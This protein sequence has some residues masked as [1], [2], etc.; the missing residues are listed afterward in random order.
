MIF[1]EKPCIM[2]TCNSC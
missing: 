2:L 1:K